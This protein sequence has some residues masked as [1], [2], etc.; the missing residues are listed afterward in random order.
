MS[1]N[2][3]EMMSVVS[4]VSVVMAS[5]VHIRAL[6]DGDRVI[7]LDVSVVIIGHEIL[8]GH[9]LIRGS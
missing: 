8:V 4:P 5:V 1:V 7:P 2:F 3:L 9:E 6:I